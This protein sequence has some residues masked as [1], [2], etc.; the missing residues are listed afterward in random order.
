MCFSLTFQCVFETFEFRAT[1]LHAR[2][3]QTY[4][5]DMLR[6]RMILSEAKWRDIEIYLP[7]AFFKQYKFQL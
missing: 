6:H 3:W 1:K 2:T 5:S 7:N 4:L